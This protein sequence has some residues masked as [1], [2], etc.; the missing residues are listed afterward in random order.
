MENLLEELND[1]QEN[2]IVIEYD[3][4]L[5]EVCISDGHDG[6]TADKVI[7]IND[8]VSIAHE[9]SKAHG[10]WEEERSFGEQIALMH[11][12][13]SE[14]L[15][16]FRNK[17]WLQ[18]IYY[19]CYKPKDKS[20]S[21]FYHADPNLKKLKCAPCEHGKP[22]GIPVELADCI[23]R[24]MD[25]CGHYSIDLDAVIREKMKYNESRPYKHGGKII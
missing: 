11:S 19:E 13:L 21:A 18:R 17:N 24:I 4:L 8:F 7:G 3:G 5:Q 22:C 20:C 23:I 25:T 15:E 2:D 10:W 1:R 16:E 6:Q 14:A 12:E 9:N